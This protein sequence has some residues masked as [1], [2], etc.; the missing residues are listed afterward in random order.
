MDD[1]ASTRAEEVFCAALELDHDAR[2]QYLSAECSNNAALRGEVDELLAAHVAAGSFLTRP[3]DDRQVAV[4]LRAGSGEE[5]EDTFLLERYRLVERIGEGGMGVV[6]RAEQI[7]GV[8]RTVAIKVVKGGFATADVLSRF[9][10]ERQALARM[11]HPNIAKVLDAGAT[12]S[13]RPFFVMELV[14][15]KPL[16]AFCDEHRLS[17]RDRLQL[18]QQVCDAIQHAHHKGIIHRDLKPGNILVEQQESRVRPKVIDFGLAKAVGE[19]LSEATLHTMVGV[20]LG[21]PAY[22]SPEQTMLSHQDID[23]RS[24]LFS[25]GVLLYELLTGTTPVPREDLAGLSLTAAFAAVR[26]HESP[27]PSVRLK[28]LDQRLPT[29]AMQRSAPAEHLIA[30]IRGDLDWICLKALEK[31]R[32]RR[33]QTASELAADV[34]RFLAD[35]PVLARPPSARYRVGTFVQR[36]RLSVGL[37]A[38]LVFALLTGTG[39][40]LTL[41]FR[42]RE[43]EADLAAF[44]TFLADDVLAAARPEGIEG[45]LGINVTVRD[46]LIAAN[47]KI[48]ERFSGRLGA[49]ALTRNTL[50]ITFA[51]LGDSKRAVPE[52]ERAWALRR[53]TLGERHPKTLNTMSRLGQMYL[54]VGRS[55][56]AITLLSETLKAQEALLGPNHEDTILTMTSL[57]RTYCRADNA[58][59]LAR[60]VGLCEEALERSKRTFGA[61]SR[62][63]WLC[64]INL[65]QAYFHVGRFSDAAVLHQKVLENLRAILPPSSPYTLLAMNDLA[66]DYL[67]ARD[68]EKAI[69]LHHEAMELQKTQL[70]DEHPAVL[71]SMSNLAYDYLLKEDFAAAEATARKCLALRTKTL[72]DTHFDTLG[73][74]MTLVQSLLAQ[75]QHAAAEPLSREI[76]TVREKAIPNEWRTHASRLLV[77]ESL[78]GSRRPEEANPLL[79]ESFRQLKSGRAKIPIWSTAVPSS[80]ERI[81][82]LYATMSDAEHAGTWEQRQREWAEWNA[83]RKA[84]IEIAGRGA[85]VAASGAR[86]R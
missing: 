28:R 73:I 69:R 13:G 11:N 44:A 20:M 37:A 66:L 51:N 15:G 86:S 81:A 64:M 56:D 62:H 52:L 50:G 70:G 77:A 2:E 3:I 35:E 84:E 8:R 54:G 1:T 60:A 17:I 65:G 53:K 80:L 57:G 33:Y 12:S 72:G 82:R 5:R 74:K 76:L 22:M 43:S 58:P 23:T 75:N 32:S 39:I 48:P 38:G 42:A 31:D 40:S 71:L 26:E 19:H 27:S 63:S 4:A 67:G 10:I 16:A 29:I 14:E 36:H 25:L 55:T 45:G 85:D 68:L 7:A 6:W 78:L 61:D 47:D 24:D 46:A 34:G 18:F 21:T 59:N 41:M 9:E 30:T 83:S 49:E 79:E